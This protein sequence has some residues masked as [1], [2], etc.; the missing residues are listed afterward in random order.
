MKS[1]QIMTSIP[2]RPPATVRAVADLDTLFRGFA[3]ETRLRIL[4][5]LAAGELCVSDIVEILGLP[6]STVSRHLAYLRRAG[7]VEAT[8]E[9][10]F[11]DYRLTRPGHPVHRNLL[12][13]VR[14]CFTGIASLD[15]ERA[16]AVRRVA[17]RES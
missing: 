7:L 11:A 10:K 15:R 6:Q 16:A 5:L 8:R 12:N 1:I 4:N 13:C 14:S 17:V 3:D 2:V 9:L